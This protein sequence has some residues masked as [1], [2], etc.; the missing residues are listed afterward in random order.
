MAKKK[1]LSV[2]YVDVHQDGVLKRKGIEF[3]DNP[4][5]TAVEQAK[6]F[7]A[8]HKKHGRKCTARTK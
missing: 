5:E 8:H 1:D 3:R 7:A 2:I 4:T 6:R